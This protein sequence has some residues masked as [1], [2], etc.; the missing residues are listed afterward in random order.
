LKIFD[1]LHKKDGGIYYISEDKS[2]YKIPWNIT[3]GKYTWAEKDST[4]KEAGHLY[5]SRLRFK[6]CWRNPRTIY[7]IR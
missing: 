7:N 5:N 4:I 3:D 6:L 1:S 2:N